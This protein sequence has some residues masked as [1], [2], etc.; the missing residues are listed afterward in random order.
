L[1]VWVGRTLSLLTRN[2]ANM[3]LVREFYASMICEEYLKEKSV[4]VRGVDVFVHPQEI[5]A[6]YQTPTHSLLKKRIPNNHIFRKYHPDL[7]AVLRRNME[8]MGHWKILYCI[9]HQL[10]IDVGQQIFD[11]I[12]RAGK[13]STS[14]LPFPCMI[15]HLCTQARVSAREDDEIKALNDPCNSETFTDITKDADME[16]LLPLG[17]TKR[18]K[19]DAA[20]PAR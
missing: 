17:S 11:A 15:T 2:T 6:Y 9:K 10:H 19:N 18:L 16:R 8:N 20:S 12:Y 14:I 3:S 13:K 1:M 7:A 4:N 5:N